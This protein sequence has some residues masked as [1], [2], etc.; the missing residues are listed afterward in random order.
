MQ[1][2]GLSMYDVY[3]VWDVCGRQLHAR[4][5]ATQSHPSVVPSTVV[6]S[7][8]CKLPAHLPRPSPAPH[9]S[10]WGGLGDGEPAAATLKTD[11]DRILQADLVRQC[12]AAAVV[13]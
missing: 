5:S 6:P 4:S 9:R 11:K 3:L 13:G 8:H 2:R 10:D 1:W 12:A 7:R